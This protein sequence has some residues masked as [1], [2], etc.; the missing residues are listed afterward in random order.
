MLSSYTNWRELAKE[1]ARSRREKKEWIK[2]VE[3]ESEDESEVEKEFEGGG[4]GEAEAPKETMKSGKTEEEVKVE[5]S[6]ESSPEKQTNRTD[7]VTDDVRRRFDSELR[8]DPLGCNWTSE[9]RTT[10]QNS[11]QLGVVIAW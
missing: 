10:H 6:T 9:C 8:L 7:D 4:R 11:Q 3:D 1:E 2:F 5:P